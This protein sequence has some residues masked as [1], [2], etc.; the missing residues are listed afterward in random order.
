[1]Y[2]FTYLLVTYR[3][4]STCC[5]YSYLFVVILIYFL[6][7]FITNTGTISLQVSIHGQDLVP[8]L[9]ENTSVW[10]PK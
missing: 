1:M 3:T 6:L 4:V 2:K 9:Y 7:F 10:D 8:K 5:T